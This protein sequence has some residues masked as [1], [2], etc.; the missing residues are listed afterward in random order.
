VS[1]VISDAL[2]ITALTHLLHTRRR[3]RASDE[4]IGL[5]RVNAIGVSQELKKALAHTIWRV[6][7]LFC[8][9]V[10]LLSAMKHLS[11]TLPL[12]A[13]GL[14]LGVGASVWAP[15]AKAQNAISINNTPSG[16]SV[17]GVGEVRIKPDIA[18]LV[19]G[20]QTQDKDPQRASSQN[21]ALA[22]A[23]IA[24]IRGAGVEARDIQTAGFSIAPQ[25]D[26]NPRPN[27][28]G[29]QQPVL[30]GYQVSNEVRVTVRRVEDAGRVLDAGIRAG[31]NTASGL[32]FDIQ[33][34]DEARDAAL[35]LAVADCA[36]KARVM[37][38]AAGLGPIRLLALTEG[39]GDSPRP[40]P[41][42]ARAMSADAA[43]TPVSA[44]EIVVS[45]SVTAN[46][47]FEGAR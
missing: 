27:A 22:Q 20:V 31:A 26:Y 30:M 18:R 16:I 6:R 33:N 47:G 45:A 10:C 11:N 4:Y 13:L 12:L 21:A 2:Q 23:V 8:S 42:F 46:Y 34:R 28:T 43:Q 15:Q 19:L 41:V 3:R 29:P 32:S 38:T 1:A 24:A 36:R 35:K 9:R 37:A 40:Y 25:Y 14:A 17:S 39:G 44:G 7:E 5:R